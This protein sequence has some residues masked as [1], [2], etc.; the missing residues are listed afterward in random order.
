MKKQTKFDTEAA[1]K[2]VVNLSVIAIILLMLKVLTDL[3]S[4]SREKDALVSQVGIWGLQAALLVTTSY[5]WVR[6]QSPSP[7]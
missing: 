4:M 5:A 3:K 1:N 2:I 6:N 7:W